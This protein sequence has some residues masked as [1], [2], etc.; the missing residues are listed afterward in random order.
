LRPVADWDEDFVLSLPLGENDKFERK[1]TKL[2]DLTAGADESKV[3]S[4]L[5]KQ[6]SAF[7]NTGGG[8]I[9][10]GLR[11]DGSI[12]QGGISDTIRGSTKEWMEDII[13]ILTDFE[14]VGVNVYAIS[15]KSKGK[16]LLS[17]GKSLY[18]VDVPDS[19]RAPHQSTLDRLY[20]VRLGGKSKPASHRLIEDIRN[21]AKHPD[22]D[23][24]IALGEIT[25]F[26]T[27]LPPSDVVVIAP[28]TLRLQNKG[29]LKSNDT[30]IHFHFDVPFISVLWH[31]VSLIDNRPDET[32]L[33]QAHFWELAGPLYPEMS[34]NVTIRYQFP[35]SFSH[36]TAAGAARFPGPCWATTTFRD[37]ASAALKWTVFADNAPPKKQECT[38]D[39]LGFNARMRDLIAAHPKGQ[40]IVQDCGP[41]P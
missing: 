26:G 19:S 33:G 39:Q 41:L 10:Y 23:L 27:Q 38:L 32:T 3:R 28:V 5:A 29:A 4:E 14:I 17:K 1:G 22:V 7:G 16:S 31:D 40:Q 35:T 25:L 8:Q 2:L 34:I 18:V 21:R 12:D 9:V 30:C 24:K 15:P 13:P 36:A 37:V 6:L 20:Y 11:D